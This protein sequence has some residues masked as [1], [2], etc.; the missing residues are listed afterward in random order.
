MGV[1]IAEGLYD[2]KEGPITAHAVELVA[3]MVRAW[4]RTAVEGKANEGKDARYSGSSSG[5]GLRSTSPTPCTWRWGT[6]QNGG[7]WA[8]TEGDS[9][10]L[11]S[12]K[13]GGTL[14]SSTAKGPPD[15][16]RMSPISDSKRWG[17]RT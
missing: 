5:R 9:W 15:G 1:K 2:R 6:M 3:G 11:P 4:L 17:K 16:E 8:R 14:S 10:A 7:F 13:N 12:S